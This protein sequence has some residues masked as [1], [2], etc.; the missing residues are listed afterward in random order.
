MCVYVC[1]RPFYSLL[2]QQ[3]ICCLL[4]AGRLGRTASM[5]LSLFTFHRRLMRPA[6][7]FNCTF[8]VTHTHTDNW[9]LRLLTFTATPIYSCTNEKRTE[10][11]QMRQV[12]ARWGLS[13]QTGGLLGHCRWMGPG[14]AP[15]RQAC[16][17]PA[18][19]LQ[20]SAGRWS[21]MVM[22]VIR[23]RGK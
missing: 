14:R 17:Q 19:A 13:K 2:C 1:V 9:T 16:L 5:R 6:N 7:R 4:S 11:T 15:V 21:C 23:K 8:S 18:P 3:A 12:W 20:C 10:D 22:G